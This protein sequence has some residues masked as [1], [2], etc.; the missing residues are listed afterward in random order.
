MIRP[1]EEKF[2]KIQGDHEHKVNRL[3]VHWDISTQC[4]LHCDYCYAIKEYEPNGHWGKIDSWTRQKLVIHALSKSSLPIFLGFQGGEPTIHP[5]FH[6]ILSLSW[7][8]INRHEDSRLYITTNSLQTKDFFDKFPNIKEFPNAIKENNKSKIYFLWSIH[9]DY[10]DKYINFIRNIKVMLKKGYRSK[11]N[12]MLHPDKK[13]WKFIKEII[14]ELLKLD[15]EIHP[16]FLYKDGD[17]HVLYEYSNE[18]YK[19]FKY[20]KTLTNQSK[21][22]YWDKKSTSN[23]QFFTDQE[24][25][26]KKLTHFKGW[27]CYNNNYEINYLGEV[28]QFCFNIL[29]D[30]TSNFN[31]FKDIKKVLPKKCIQDGCY[32]DG[33]LKIKKVYNEN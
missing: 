23:A 1:E 14:S 22:L 12:I 33:L 9:F 13:Y 28:K 26:V 31:F 29:E 18:F 8:A 2:I 3:Y 30:L 27:D 20:L 17:A 11:I 10:I 32:C 19:E 4:Q 16:H 15:V 21:F 5:K 25:F 24:L 7:K 6:E